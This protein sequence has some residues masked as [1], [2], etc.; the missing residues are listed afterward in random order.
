M[1]TTPTDNAARIELS[2]IEDIRQHEVRALHAAFSRR[3]W[4]AA[5]QAGN[6]LRDKLDRLMIEA[7]QTA[8]ATTPPPDTV[9]LRAEVERLLS[10]LTALEKAAA[11]AGKVQS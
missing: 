7:R 9:A 4:H 3:D 2:A 6:N 10:S 5:E 1:T 8:R 11:D